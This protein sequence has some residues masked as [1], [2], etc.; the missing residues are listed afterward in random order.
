MEITGIVNYE[1]IVKKST[2]HGKGAFSLQQINKGK[3]IG[4]LAGSITTIRKIRQQVR[5]KKSIAAVELDHGL[6]LD[7][8][9]FKNELC[10]VNHSCR[11]NCY[12]R[13][14]N[15]HVEMYALRPIKKNEELTC[16]YGETHHDGKLACNCG[17]EDC[18]RKL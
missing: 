14:I 9:A 4:S 6:A 12:M 17:K 8:T 2:I 10:F 13:I 15:K 7:C 16:D 18:R 3:K 11:P 5:Q 1:I